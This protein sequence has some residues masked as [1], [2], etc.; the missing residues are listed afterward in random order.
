MKFASQWC[1][2]TSMDTI[3]FKIKTTLIKNM[4][5]K[6]YDSDHI[7]SGQRTLNMHLEKKNKKIQSKRKY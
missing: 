7:E 6:V 5:D 3:T 4:F 1:V 2:Y